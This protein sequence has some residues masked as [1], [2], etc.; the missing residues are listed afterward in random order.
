MS[1][2]ANAKSKAPKIQEKKTPGLA[3]SNMTGTGP[4]GLSVRAF[5]EWYRDRE[6]EQWERFDYAALEK[7]A[8]AI[9]KVEKSGKTIFVMGNGGSAATASHI[10]TDWSKTAE[11]VNKP[12]IRCISLND[13]T[14]FMTA[15]GNDLGYDEIF[16][17]QLRNLCGKGDLVVIISGSGNS[18]SVLKA[19]DYAKSVGATTVGLTGFTGGKLRKDVDICFHVESD[20]YGVIEDMHMAAGS[21]LAFYLKQRK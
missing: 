20:Q 17:R 11:R 12:L 3:A 5:A 7:I 10:A 8:K 18:P 15:I 19:N 4:G 1:K 13:N 2:Q 14:A 6:L 16:A 21:I 9:E